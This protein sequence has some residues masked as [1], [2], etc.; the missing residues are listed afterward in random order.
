LTGYGSDEIKRTMTVATEQLRVFINE[1]AVGTIERTFRGQLSFSYTVEYQSFEHATPLSVSMPLGRTR[2]AHEQVNVWLAGLLPDNQDVL[3]R[4]ATRYETKADVFSL[5]STPIG[6]DCPGAVQLIASDQPDQFLA[7]A[8]ALKW[9]STNDVADRLRALRIDS[10]EWQTADSIGRWSLAGAQ[11][12][13]ALYRDK[14]R[15][16]EATGRTP[17]THILKPAISGLV[18]QDI[19]EHVCLRAAQLVGVAAADSSIEMFGDQRALIVNRFDRM[20]TPLG[21]QR[22]HQE[23]LCQALS[24]SPAL[25]YQSDGGPGV[26]DIGKLFARISP[27]GDDRLPKAFLD[28]LIFNWIIGGSDAHAKN[29]S[30]LL[31]GDQVRLAPLYDISSVLPYE[32]SRGHKVKLAMKYGSEY[33]LL[34][35]GGRAFDSVAKEL[36][37]SVDSVRDRGRM[38]TDNIGDAFST[39][40][41]ALPVEWAKTQGPLLKLIGERARTCSPAFS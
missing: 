38:L 21:I 34:K 22:V 4:W 30:L 36:G 5:L 9:L 19:N 11:A 26:A 29:Y 37:L 1:V 7:R 41:G 16:A 6:R 17:T 2:H 31:H 14:S 32:D 18:D 3:R 33:R 40:I 24:V 10:A 27:S 25:K 8:K 12:K 15:W 23:D 20:R 35:I 13:C 28:G 39:S